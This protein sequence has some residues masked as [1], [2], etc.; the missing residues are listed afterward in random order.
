M[1]LLLKILSLQAIDH[2]EEV[3]NFCLEKGL[4]P[5]VILTVFDTPAALATTT[6]GPIGFMYTGASR[7]YVRRW[8]DVAN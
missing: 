4:T 2:Y 6:K 8:L 1:A 7:A 5:I 3:I